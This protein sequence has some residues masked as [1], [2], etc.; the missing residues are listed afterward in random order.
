MIFLCT[1][2]CTTFS[3]YR[4]CVVIFQ[5]FVYSQVVYFVLWGAFISSPIVIVSMF[6]IFF[7]TSIIIYAVLSHHHRCWY[8]FTSINHWC[9]VFSHHHRCWYFFYQH[10]PLMPLPRITIDIHYYFYPA[11]TA[12]ALSSHHHRCRLFFL[13]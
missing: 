2:G 1:I 5:I 11:S 8:F 9:L 13:P 4:T 6:I 10:Q 3:L 7:L 12:D